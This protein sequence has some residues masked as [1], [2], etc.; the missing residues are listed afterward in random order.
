MFL[1][2]LKAVMLAKSWPICVWQKRLHQ[3]SDLLLGLLVVPHCP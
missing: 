2:F 3:T 1:I